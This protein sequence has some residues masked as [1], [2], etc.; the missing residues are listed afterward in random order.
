M[1]DFNEDQIRVLNSQ[2]TLCVVAGAGSGKTGT[3]VEYLVRFVERDPQNNS[4]TNILAMTFSEKAAAEMRLRVAQSISDRLRTADSKASKSLWEREM[5]RLGQAQI[6]TIHGYALGLVKSHSH[7]LGLPAGLEVDANDKSEDV[8]EALLDLLESGQEDLKSLLNEL[9]LSSSGRFSQASLKRWLEICQAKLSSWGLAGL[10]NAM[11]SPPDFK[12]ERD[13]KDLE[14]KVNSALEYFEDASSNA[15]KY[16]VFV[17]A[18]SDLK[19]ALAGVNLNNS[20]NV[21]SLIFQ[22]DKIFRRKGLDPQYKIPRAHRKEI[23]DGVKKLVKDLNEVDIYPV[24]EAFVNLSNHLT[25]KARFKRFSMGLLSF[26][27]ILALARD[28]LRQHARIRSDEAGRWRLIM[29]DEFQDT[30]RLQTDIITQLIGD[31]ASGPSDWANLKWADL[32]PKL[33]VVGDPKQSIYRF[34]GSESEIMDNLTCVLNNGGGEVLGLSTNYRTQ[35]KLIDFYN[36][37]FPRYLG[38]GDQAKQKKARPDLYQGPSVVWL[39]AQDPNSRAKILKPG[40]QARM[41]ADYL[42]EL[43]SGRT[44]VMV[45][46]KPQGGMEPLVRP[47]KPTDVAILLR[48]KRNAAI[49]QETLTARGIACHT[50]KGRDIFLAPEI[51]GLTSA[52]LYLCGR[53]PDMN[54][55]SALLSPLGPVAETTLTALTWPEQSEGFRPLS[56]YFEADNSFFPPN[57][58]AQDLSALLALKGLFEALKPYVFRRPPGEII[59]ALVEER[60]LLPMIV[61]GDNGSPERVREV[62]DFLAMVKAIGYN[63][64][65]QPLSGA[66]QLEK[67]R[68][69]GFFKGEEDADSTE[70]ELEE[71][72]V[73]IMTVHRSKGLE[74]PVVVIAEA[75]ALASN[76]ND[77]ILI[78]ADGS[79][80]INYR[81]IKYGRKLSCD[82]YLELQD[83]DKRGADNEAKRL[84]YVGATRARDHLVLVGQATEKAADKKAAKTEGSESAKS[85]LAS[86]VN[87]ENFSQHVGVI[88]FNPP[89]EPVEISPTK[90]LASKANIESAKTE[91]FI[92]ELVLPLPPNRTISMGVTDYCRL[93]ETLKKQ[94]KA[95][96]TPKM[97]KSQEVLPEQLTFDL[98]SQS[99]NFEQFDRFDQIGNPDALGF[100]ELAS[101]G[102]SE[103]AFKFAGPTKPW[104]LGTLFHAAMEVT[105]YKLD[106]KSSLD[107]LNTEAQRL[108]LSPSQGE[109]EF[110]ADKVLLF[111]ESPLG[112]KA[113]QALNRNRQI[114]R[115]WPFWLRLESDQFGHGPIYLSGVIDL[116]FVDEQGGGV[117]V[118]YKLSK[119]KKRNPVYQ[120]QLEIYSTVVRQAGFDGSKALETHLW[121]ALS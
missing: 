109:L 59:E 120:R 14:C 40:V 21:R 19:A 79:V 85:W 114:Q 53:E 95:Q 38:L 36:G 34:R 81:S 105:D 8:F 98:T 55:A 7:L 43:F 110:L 94:S 49:Y 68:R 108:C 70:G 100:S 41:V 52:Y 46:D 73:N 6:S 104:E 89:P 113:A 30:N 80:A 103:V 88:D 67:I 28:L 10:K 20:I 16:P 11:G 24:T 75:D 2:K 78:G 45:S 86:I 18:V 118:D 3:L 107:L 58:E 66:D 50:L 25:S 33:K 13:L 117:I 51:N 87:W 106:K 93:V 116:F 64:P 61:S 72:A 102:D 15:K 101:L 56:W 76:R 9:V 91:A 96:I 35:G 69:V 1:A 42:T 4:L 48:F 121:Y 90:P 99:D 119:P 65:Q 92:P 12:P 74:F 77:G 27:D 39:K 60:H 111:Q 26:D 22:A 44:G 47:P 97:Y 57:I 82:K 62:Q 115:E 17:E 83:W 54:L 112:R 32:S 5:R 37:F 29:V 63:D 71:G 84:L 31:P 23:E